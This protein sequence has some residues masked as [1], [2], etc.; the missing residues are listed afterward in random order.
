MSFFKSALNLKRGIAMQE[1][2]YIILVII[3]IFFAFIIFIKTSKI[4]R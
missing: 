1:L 3:A 2:I 4:L